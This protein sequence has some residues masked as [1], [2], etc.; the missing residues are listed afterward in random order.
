MPD[1]ISVAGTALVKAAS[2]AASSGPKDPQTLIARLL[3]P[4]VDEFGVALAPQGA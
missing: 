2:A 3:G 4:A 1:T